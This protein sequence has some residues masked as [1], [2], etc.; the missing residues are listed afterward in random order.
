MLVFLLGLG[1]GLGILFWS[2]FRLKAQLK[3]VLKASPDSDVLMRSFSTTTLIRRQILFLQEQV[4]QR[5]AYLET[6]EQLIEQ[7]PLVFLR[8]DAENHLIACNQ[9][10]RAWF[11]IERWPPLRL[12]LLLELVRSYDL[13]RL[14][15]QTRQTQEPQVAEWTFHAAITDSRS[16]RQ[17][18]ASPTSLRLKGYGYALPQGQVGVFIE[19]QQS[20][21]EFAQ[22]RDRFFS[23][24]THELR[25]PLTSLS[26]LAETLEKR[27]NDPEKRWAGQILKEIERL[28]ALVQDWLDLVSIQ[29]NPHQSLH[30][31]TIDLRSILMTAWQSL[32]P[33]AQKKS[34]TLAASD[35][36]NLLL[37]GDPLRLTQVFLNLLDNSIKHSPAH[38]Q[39]QIQAERPETATPGQLTLHLIDQGSGFLTQDLPYIFDRLYRG[40]PAR[41]RERSN[42]ELS[43]PG[44]GL[45]LAIAKEIIQAHGGLIQADNHPQTHGA[46]LKITL[47]L[48]QL[49]IA[50]TPPLA[51][52]EN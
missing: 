17:S 23:D 33:L 35:L 11:N 44:S 12:R 16:D 15:V 40:D 14:I 51:T 18:N 46:W 22:K 7:A 34:I 30:F 41:A 25:T 29:E 8:I 39:I 26:L 1:L 27:L 43:R 24:L 50:T 49:P 19:N 31:Q 10:A 47:P 52:E 36:P 3:T 20:F 5:E 4:K 45:G 21:Q 9:Q 48:T 38:S 2:H 37:E 42:T 32:E 28:M 6:W 13:D